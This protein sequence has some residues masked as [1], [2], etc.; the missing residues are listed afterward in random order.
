METTK[1]DFT[2]HTPEQVGFQYVPAGLGSRGAAFFL[3]FLIRAFFVLFIFVLV[4]LFSAVLPSLDPSGVLAGISGSWAVA[5][6]I[7]AYGLVDLGY[8]LFFEAFWNGQ[9]PGKKRFNLR[10]IR[11]NGQP[12]G[13]VESAVRNL[14]RALDILGGVYPLGLL[15]IFLSRNNQRIGDYA[16][17]TLVV[18]E[19]RGKIP[20]GSVLEE[21][22][23]ESLF[24]GMEIQ[25]LHLEARQYQL[26]RSFLERREEMNPNHRAD[27]A[28]TLARRLM[29]HWEIRDG[30]EADYEL[31]LERVVALYEAR[32]KAV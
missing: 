15:V 25:V 3:D 10:V 24:P 27:L 30:G 19:E 20:M 22:S 1:G 21:T 9:T 7:L 4:S 16:A 17:G 29:E 2:V 5:L 23:K 6:G 32:K 28:K 11:R 14:L 26:L 12:I 18:R 31:F 13:W 8:F